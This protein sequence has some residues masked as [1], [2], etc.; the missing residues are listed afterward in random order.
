LAGEIVQRPGRGRSFDGIEVPDW[1]V[2][3]QNSCFHEGG[4]FSYLCSSVS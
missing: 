4:D 2:V 1:V 3:S